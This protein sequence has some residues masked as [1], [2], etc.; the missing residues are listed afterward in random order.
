VA[1]EEAPAGARERNRLVR[2]RSF[3][4]TAFRIVTEEGFDGLTMQRLADECDA[5]IGAVYRYF[6]SKGALVAEVQKE[7]IERLAT[8]YEVIRDRGDRAWSDVDEADVALTRLVLFGR[9]F[10]ATADT[11]PQELR[12][13]YMLMN[14][15]RAVVPVEEG[16]RVVP[17]AMRLLD[18]MR[19]GIDAAVAS[20][21]LEG[22][23][24]PMGRVVTWVAAVAG[25]LQVSHL[26]VYDAEL[27]DGQRLARQLSYDL[28]DAW[29]ATPEGLRAAIGRVDELELTGPL[30]PPIPVDA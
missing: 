25:V 10:C 6:P 30:A 8:S 22:D 18:R 24:D 27:F 1:T 12:L 15:W 19:Q 23:G 11:F 14:E 5:A 9:F 26:E 7:A 20:G 4:A 17:S 3:L 2:A 16:M 13:L 29:G 21:S 28:L